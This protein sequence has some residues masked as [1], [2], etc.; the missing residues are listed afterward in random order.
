LTLVVTHYPT[1]ASK[2][3]WIEHRLFCPISRSWAGQ[4]LIDYE[5]ILKFSRTTRTEQ[6][7]QCIAHVDKADDAWGRTLSIEQKQSIN[8]RHHRVLPKWNYTLKPRTIDQVIS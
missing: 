5:T 7:L 2:W 4:P 1:S 8:V 3:N 6:G